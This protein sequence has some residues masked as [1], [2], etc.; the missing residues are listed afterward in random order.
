MLSIFPNLFNYS[1][2]APTILKVAV[3]LILIF[4]PYFF[5]FSDKYRKITA[6]FQVIIGLFLITGMYTQIITP[7]IVL[8][9]VIE[10]IVLK[11]RG[12]K[13]ENGLAKFLLLIISIS[14]MFSGPGL[15]SIDLP[16]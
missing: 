11:I 4:Y 2:L 10:A 13:I 5:H 16:L 7:L 3:A 14:L 9:I 1:Y 15:F 6:F 12:I 8:L